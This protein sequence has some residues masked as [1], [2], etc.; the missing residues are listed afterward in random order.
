MIS[1]FL[2]RIFLKQKNKAKANTERAKEELPEGKGVEGGENRGKAISPIE[3]DRNG[4]S[5]DEYT[6]I[7]RSQNIKLYTWGLYNA[8]NYCHLKKERRS[9]ALFQVH[10]CFFKT[11]HKS[12][13]RSV[14]SDSLRPRGLYSPWSSPGQN[15]GVGSCFCLQGIFPT[16]ELNSG[17]PHCGPIL[18]QLRYQGSPRI[19]GWVAYPFSSRSSWPRNRT[20]VSCLAGRFF[21]SWAI[22]EALLGG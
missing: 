8:I 11:A 4:T 15:T 21:T 10:T 2:C 13:S 6:A 20:R 9:W 14:V 22:R 7:Y 5:Y 18:Y 1:L 16:Q 17:L 19:L 3:M 12:E